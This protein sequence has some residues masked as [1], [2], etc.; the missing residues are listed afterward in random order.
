MTIDPCQADQDVTAVVGWADDRIVTIQGVE[1][2]PEVGRIV[3]GAIA[4]D[5]YDFVGLPQCGR[6]GMAQPF[7]QIVAALDPERIA[8]YVLAYEL[9]LTAG[10]ELE[11]FLDKNRAHTRVS[12]LLSGGDS[13]TVIELE[14]QLL[15]LSLYKS[16]RTGK[17]RKNLTDAQF[18]TRALERR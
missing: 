9:S 4:A 10:Q 13:R 16:R 7:T 17:P 2:H 12:V 11:D 5:E 18:T 14:Q 6:K 1:R 8:Q 3:T 15:N